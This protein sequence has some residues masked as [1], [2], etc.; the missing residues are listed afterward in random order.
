RS[1]PVSAAVPPCLTAS[2]MSRVLGDFEPSS[3]NSGKGLNAAAM[4]QAFAFCSPL[5]TYRGLVLLR[6]GRLFV[7]EVGPRGL[8]FALGGAFFRIGTGFLVACAARAR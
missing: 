3:T 7:V 6:L 5:S 1:A 2:A 4:P 8:A